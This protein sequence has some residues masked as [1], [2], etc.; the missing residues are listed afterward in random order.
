MKKIKKTFTIIVP[1][2][3]SIMTGK[4]IREVVNWLLENVPLKEVKITIEE[5]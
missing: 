5:L 2:K 1:E 3:F 4:E